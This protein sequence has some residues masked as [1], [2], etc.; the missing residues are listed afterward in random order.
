[1]L[2]KT[3]QPYAAVLDALFDD[4]FIPVYS[5]PT[6]AELERVLKGKIAHEHPGIYTDADVN[7][8]IGLFHELGEYIEIEG[9][10]EV[11]EDDPD[12]NC[13]VETA[14]EARVQYLVAEDRHFRFEKAVRFLRENKIDL[15]YPKQFLRVLPDD[16]ND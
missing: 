15:L 14:V 12:D 3:G 7:E 16:P 4:R 2:G 10:L 8:F 1:M 6:I 13:F 11:V 9:T 5:R